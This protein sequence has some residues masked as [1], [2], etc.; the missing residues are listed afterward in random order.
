MWNTLSHADL[1]AA[2][3]RLKSQRE[4]TLRR[5]AEE[6]R[7]LESDQ[8][9]LENLDQLIAAFVKK[10]K[11]AEIAFGPAAATDK[12][13]SSADLGEVQGGT[14]VSFFITQ[15]Q[16]SNLRDLGIADE[17]IR[18]MKPEEAGHIIADADATFVAAACLEGDAPPRHRICHRRRSPGRTNRSSR[19]RSIGDTQRRC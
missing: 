5:H 14:G 9:E 12:D 16:K 6:L 7:A 4:E 13:V 2:K 10:F 15:A 8:A 1:D 17:Q 18:D 3:H 11:K 19:A